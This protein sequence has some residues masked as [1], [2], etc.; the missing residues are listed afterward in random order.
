MVSERLTSNL[1][2]SNCETSQPKGHEAFAAG[3]MQAPIQIP[4]QDP[5]TAKHVLSKKFARLQIL[6][7]LKKLLPN[8]N[9]LRHL[10]TEDRI[11]SSPRK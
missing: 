7:Q 4:I 3:K 11:E 2:D 6:Y 9:A 5:Q 1:V 10:D 8:T